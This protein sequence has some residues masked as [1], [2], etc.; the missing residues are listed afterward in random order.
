MSHD[1]KP[2]IAFPV[3]PE[4]GPVKR[5]AV[6]SSSCCQL[7]T[8]TVAFSIDP[9][10]VRTGRRR[11]THDDSLRLIDDLVNRPVDP[12]FSDAKLVRG[13]RSVCSIW[14]TRVVV[15]LICVF[16]GFSSSLFVQQL[17]SDPRKAVR[18]TLASELES[19]NK[20]AES[21][22]G[23]VTA[24]RNQIDQLSKEVSGNVKSDTLIRDEMS[25][26]M[27]SV[28][29][30][31]ITMTIADPIAADQSNDTSGHAGA[32]SQI[33]IVTDR[34]LQTIVSL[35]FQNG[36]EAIAINGNRLGVRTSI[37]AAGGHILIGMVAVESPYVIEAIGNKDELASA[38]GEKGQKSLYDSF[39]EA[40]IYPQVST[41]KSLTLKAAVSGDVQYARRSE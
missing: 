28:T 26:G 13:H 37:R 15:C 22:T 27:T 8:H 12:M 1:G 38:M 11:K 2:L 32:G 25:S 19:N 33:R 21:L 20:R 10:A 5:R 30:E 35:M 14:V 3:Q 6:F 41:S 9:Q 18:Q 23:E 39:K 24:L 40:G 16:V 7:S 4:S 31:G 29:G 17:K 34:D 36:A